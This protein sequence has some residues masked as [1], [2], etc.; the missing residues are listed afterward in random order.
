VSALLAVLALTLAGP[1]SRTIRSPF[2]D[3]QERHLKG[4][5]VEY[6]WVNRTRT[7]LSRLIQA[8]ASMPET[9]GTWDIEGG[10]TNIMGRQGWNKATFKAGAM[11]S[12]WWRI[13]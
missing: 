1:R 4:K 10:S 11:R 5:V 2:L 13:R 12:P 7:S 3:G 8:T 9:V 6:K